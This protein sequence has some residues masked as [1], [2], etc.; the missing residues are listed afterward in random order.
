MDRG[1]DA[2]GV[3]A[4][5]KAHDVIHVPPNG[6]SC[7]LSKSGDVSEYAA[8]Q[9]PPDAVEDLGGVVSTKNKSNL[10]HNGVAIRGGSV[11]AGA[12]KREEG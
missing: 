1:F 12:R 8:L 5:H 3:L 2:I 10:Y 6:D 9:G 11:Q 4:G 7:T